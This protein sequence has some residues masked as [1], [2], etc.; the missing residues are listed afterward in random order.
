MSNEKESVFYAF[1]AKFVVKLL[2]QR[3]IHVLF[4]PHTCV[5]IV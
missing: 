5:P 2:T 3:K 4:I 1:S